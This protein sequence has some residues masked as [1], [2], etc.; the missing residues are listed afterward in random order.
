MKKELTN[1]QI[2]EL[3]SAIDMITKSSIE[4]EVPAFI[5]LSITKNKTDAIAEGIKNAS[6]SHKKYNE[7]IEAM[8][9]IAIEFCVIKKNGKPDFIDENG[10]FSYNIDEEKQD[11]FE[12]CVEQLEIRNTEVIQKEEQRKKDFENLL[13]ETQEIDIQ[14]IKS[15]DLH[16]ELKDVL[17]KNIVKAL[18]PIF[19]DI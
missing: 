17:S 19:E 6:K 12:K 15:T 9:T 14:T 18:I 13:K 4:I 5:S 7:F 11:D 16:G 2:L 8:K 1:K 3:N 10:K